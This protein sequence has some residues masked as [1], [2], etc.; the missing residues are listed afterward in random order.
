MVFKTRTQNEN[1][2]ILGWPTISNALV[3][4]LPS[5]TFVPSKRTVPTNVRA[6]SIVERFGEGKT[7]GKLVSLNDID[8]FQFFIS[9]TD[10]FQSTFKN[11]FPNN[12]T[13]PIVIPCL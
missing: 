2:S 13:S 11:F 4:P 3:V 9:M 7:H 1:V 12:P 6:L 8:R 5:E 10:K